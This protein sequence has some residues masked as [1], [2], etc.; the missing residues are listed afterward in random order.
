MLK[1]GITGGI[2][3]GKTI[4]CQVFQTLGI[5]VLYA[6]NVAKDLM[7]T[8]DELK[9]KIKDL[10]G[11]DIYDKGELQRQK[12]A[13][14]VFNNEEQLQAL[15]VLVHPAT[16]QYGI[17][18]MNK[19]ITP[20]AIKEAA[21]FFESGSDKEMD[22]MIGVHAPKDVRLKRVMLR[23]NTPK[24]KVEERMAKQMDEEEKM[25]LCD[26]VILNNDR[27]SIIPQVIEIHSKLLLRS[28]M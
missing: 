24:E 13:S 22:L 6:D 10:F 26:Y 19:Q 3:S 25:K 16:I 2:G 27:T 7:N 21:L 15:N 20:Y 11:E 28:K 14:I 23:D 4:V 5:P 8:D 9:Q 12:L 18:W 17:D 1:V